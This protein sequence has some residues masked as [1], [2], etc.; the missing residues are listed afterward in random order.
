MNPIRGLP[1]EPLVLSKKLGNSF[2]HQ[3]VGAATGLC[4]QLVQLKFLIFRQMHFHNHHRKKTRVGA[5]SID[6]HPR[7]SSQTFLLQRLTQQPF[8][9]GLIR[10]AVACREPARG[11]G[12]LHRD[13]DQRADLRNATQDGS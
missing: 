5:S 3:V 10:N 2:S 13:S 8:N 6:V 9:V 4:G 11:M 1:L 12:V 7:S